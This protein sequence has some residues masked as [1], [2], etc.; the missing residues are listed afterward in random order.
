MTRDRMLCSSA[1]LATCYDDLDFLILLPLPAKCLDYRHVPSV[2]A[3]V[4]TL[5][6]RASRMVG[7]HSIH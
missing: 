4:L 5:K 7:K 6:P 3:M 1:W 2:C